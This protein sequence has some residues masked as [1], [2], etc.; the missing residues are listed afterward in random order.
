MQENQKC[1]R[2]ICRYQYQGKDGIL[3][4]QDDL[5][6][7]VCQWEMDGGCDPAQCPALTHQWDGP[8][9]RPVWARS[10]RAER[11]AALTGYFRRLFRGSK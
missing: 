2:L 7:C 9:E 4:G 6:L 1:P 5:L 8:A 3:C 11:I 10:P